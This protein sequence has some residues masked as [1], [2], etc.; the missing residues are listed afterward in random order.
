MIIPYRGTPPIFSV[1]Q[2]NAQEMY[3]ER[4]RLIQFGFEQEG[5]SMLSA[6][7]QK[8]AGLNSG[9]AQR[10]YQDV[11]SERFAALERRYTNFY[12]DLAYQIIHKA[13]EIGEREGSYA[14]IFTDRK[15]GAKEIELPEIKL[16]NDPFVIQAYTESSLPKDPAGR[17]QKVTEM[18]QSNMISIQEGRRLLDFPDLGQKE[19]LAN[20]SEERIY[21]YLDDI[22]EEGK[23]QGPDQWINLQNATEIVTQYINLYSCCKLEEEKLQMLRDFFLQ[24]QDLQMAAMPPTAPGMP[25]APQNNLAVPQPLPQSTNLPQ[26][27]GPVTA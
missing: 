18:I 2:S 4:A 17:L 25:M 20:A 26:G 23:Y 22:I 11:N 13:K 1:S 14:T 15:K 19:T 5:L 8:P 24:I 10:V 16:L 12:V 27:P 9:E 3:E 7:S 6:T 21:C